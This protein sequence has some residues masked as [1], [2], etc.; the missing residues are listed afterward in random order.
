MQD[1]GDNN[2]ASIKYIRPPSDKPPRVMSNKMLQGPIQGFEVQEHLS[3]LASPVIMKNPSATHF[4]SLENHAPSANSFGTTQ[5]HLNF[6]AKPL[7]PYEDQTFPLD[8]VLHLL[9]FNLE[10][11]PRLLRLNMGWNKFIR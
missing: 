11:Y 2:Q 9:F 1:W 3:A 6:N 10:D 8:A 7:P 5:K 4:L